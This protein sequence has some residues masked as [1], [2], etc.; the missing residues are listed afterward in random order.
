MNISVKKTAL[1]I[2]FSLV[3]SLVFFLIFAFAAKASGET[4]NDIASEPPKVL[5]KLEAYDLLKKNGFKWR[6][7]D[8]LKLD[9]EVKSQLAESEMGFKSEFVARELIVRTNPITFG[10]NEDVYTVSTIGLGTSSVVFNWTLLDFATRAK[11]LGSHENEKMSAEQSLQY[12]NDLTALMLIQYLTI[13]RLKKQVETMDANLTRSRLILQFANAKKNVGAGIPLDIARAKNLVELDQLKKMTAY[14]KLIK[15]K[16]DLASLLGAEHMHSELEPL[17]AKSTPNLE[18][19]AAL[20]RSLES[21]PDLKSAELAQSIAQFAREESHRLLW[22]K[23]SFIGEVGS[24]NTTM[25]GLGIKSLNGAVGLS[26]TIPLTTGG[27]ISGKRKEAEVMNIKADMQLQ[28]TRT[29]IVAQVKEALETMISAQE[30]LKTADN[31]LNTAQEESQISE[32][33]FYSGSSNSLDMMN[34]HTNLAQAVDTH[35]ESLFNFEAAKVNYYRVM[36][37][38]NEYFRIEK[39]ESH[40]SK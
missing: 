28:Q 14:T 21:R 30:A 38:F 1:Q 3:T 20:D 24:T 18:F 17:S 39:G 10:L 11:I 29:E 37:D 4:K 15:A 22:P 2:V 7:T 23:L 9:A 19:Q 26:L 36:G 27:Y 34:S 25:L 13:Q 32:K 31:Y 5:T 12:K 33:R 8:T 40:D 35:T 16:H 6:L